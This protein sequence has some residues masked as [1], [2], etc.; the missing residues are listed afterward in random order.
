M[1]DSLWPSPGVLVSFAC[2]MEV[3]GSSSQLLVSGE[4]S[5]GWLDWS[6]DVAGSDP[7]GLW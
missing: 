1:G 4:G 2:G 5:V 7:W 6:V 3:G